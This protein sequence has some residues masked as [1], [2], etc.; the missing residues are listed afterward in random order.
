MKRQFCYF[1][2]CNITLTR[3]VGPPG[4]NGY[5]GNGYHKNNND[6]YN[7]GGN[8]YWNRPS[9][10]RPDSFVDNYGGSGPNQPYSPHYPYNNNYNGRQRP[11]FSERMH[12]EP[13]YN[14][15]A[16]NVYPQQG[17]QKSYDNVTAGS[18]SNSA[19]DQWGNSTDPS[20]VNSS[21]DRLQQAQP[22]KTAPDSYGFNGF[23]PGPQN[24]Q[25]STNNS[26]SAPPPP[27][28]GAS[29]APGSQRIVFGTPAPAADP[30]NGGPVGGARGAPPPVA[31]TTS[32]VLRK[33]TDASDTKRKN[34]FKK[35]FSKA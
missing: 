28:H 7:E 19:S 13:A 6:R 15:G 10:S 23:G 35:R 32:K 25:I 2:I 11:R 24:L 27:P 12:S 17:Y 8:N 14:N 33:N 26:Q 9:M 1:C 20:S 16:P 3:I 34:W 22:P 18:G 30:N 31:R 21:L 29:T 4:G 5:N